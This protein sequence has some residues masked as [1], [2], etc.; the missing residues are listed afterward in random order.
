MVLPSLSWILA[1]TVAMVSL[2]S[3][4]SV[5]V[6]PVSVF[7][8][9]CISAGRSPASS[10]RSLS[11]P[12]AGAGVLGCGGGGS[13]EERSGGLVVVGRLGHVVSLL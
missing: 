7:T 5:T 9:I 2:L 13:G 11:S 8:K 10:S 4:S 12:P 1:L 6:F 3:T